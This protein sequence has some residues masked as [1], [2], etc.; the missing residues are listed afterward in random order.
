MFAARHQDVSH[1]P[2]GKGTFASPRFAR[3]DLGV[4]LDEGQITHLI[5]A[6]LKYDLNDF[7]RGVFG[8][9]LQEK[10]QEAGPKHP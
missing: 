10:E 3:R 8:L 6:H 1:G 9:F 5:C 4:M 2:L 7:F